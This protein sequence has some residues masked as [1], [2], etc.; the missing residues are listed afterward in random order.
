MLFGCWN[1]IQIGAA[2]VATAQ[3]TTKVGPIDTE[4][5]AS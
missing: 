4:V 1:V 5:Q 2:G 3:L